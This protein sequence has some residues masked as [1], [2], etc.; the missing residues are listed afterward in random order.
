M[1]DAP[2]R[3]PVEPENNESIDTTG[4]CCFHCNGTSNQRKNSVLI[5]GVY[6]GPSILRNTLAVVTAVHDISWVAHHNLLS[7]A[8]E[9]VL[10][11]M[12]G[13]P[14]VSFHLYFHL[15][16]TKFGF[17]EHLHA[18]IVCRPRTDED[19]D[20]VSAL[21]TSLNADDRGVLHGVRYVKRAWDGPSQSDRVSQ[22]ASFTDLLGLS[23]RDF[24]EAIKDM[25]TQSSGKRPSHLADCKDVYGFYYPD[26]NPESD[27]VV[28]VSNEWTPVR[29]RGN[30]FPK[31]ARGGDDDRA[32]GGDD[33][34]WL[35]R[36]DDRRAFG[37]GDDRRAFGRGDDR[38]R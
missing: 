6:I 5:R 20:A 33:V 30:V 35:G 2:A 16:S 36:G 12:E 31:S 19:T 26:V 32:R 14:R 27:F 15:G 4:Y 9:Y 38:R 22:P 21:M 7:V 10:S 23:P 25:V 24:G 11:L 1:S 28:N 3:F 13:N 17:A 29:M 8:R 18:W 37:R 34:G